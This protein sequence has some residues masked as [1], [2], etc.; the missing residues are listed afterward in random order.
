MDKDN[1]KIVYR[2]FNFVL[3]PV[4]S[5]LISLIILGLVIVPQIISYFSLNAR[6]KDQ[7]AQTDDLNSKITEIESINNEDTKK[8]LEITLTIL[9]TDKDIPSA[10]LSLQTLIAKSSVAATSSGQLVLKDIIYNNS[11][12]GSVQNSFQLSL[13]LVGPLQSLKNFI[14]YLQSAPR[15]YQVESISAQFQKGSRTV[16]VELPIS[17]LYDPNAKASIS[18][19]DPVPKLGAKEAEMLN[20]L[21]SFIVPAQPEVYSSTASVPT[22]KSDPFE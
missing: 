17:V 19:S 7:I 5:V 18:F 12:K 3:L 14:T 21:N 4:I 8:G 15:L 6:I 16:E 11:K 10:I 1:L 9:P 13:T 2:R 20:K 22:G